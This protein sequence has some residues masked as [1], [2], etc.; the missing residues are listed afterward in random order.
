MLWKLKEGERACRHCEE[1]RLRED[2]LNGSLKEGEDGTVFIE[3]EE[4]T[5]LYGNTSMLLF[6]DRRLPC[7]DQLRMCRVV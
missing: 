6:E 5:C 3:A 7:G 4:Y 1:S 2:F